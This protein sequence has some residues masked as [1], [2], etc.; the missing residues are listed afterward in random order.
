M[1]DQI[2][3]EFRNNGGRV[4]G[5]FDGKPLLLLHNTGAR[6]GAQRINPLVYATD[7]E[8]YVIAASKGGADS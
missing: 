8:S 1:N 5:F 4:G 2:I 7:G 6:S 3:E